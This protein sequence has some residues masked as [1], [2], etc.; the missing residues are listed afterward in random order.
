MSKQFIFFKTFILSFF[1]NVIFFSEVVE[2]SVKKDKD[3]E[4]KKNNNENIWCIESMLMH[5]APTMWCAG[6]L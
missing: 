6:K 2:A 3:T 5:E 4:E 1:I